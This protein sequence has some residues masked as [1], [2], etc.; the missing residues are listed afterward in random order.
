VF[1]E[2][3]PDRILNT[4]SSD[5]EFDKQYKAEDSVYDYFH[6]RFAGVAILIAC[7]GLYGLA[8]FMAEL[9]FK[10][11]GSEKYWAPR[12]KPA[13]FLLTRDFLRLGAHL[14]PP[15]HS[16]FV[17]GHGQKWLGSFPIVRK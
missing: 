1:H 12:R 11:V 5:E 13:S 8:M 10:E 17:V 9:R 6:L 7:L 3:L 16:H 15:F 14:L 2:T 4:V